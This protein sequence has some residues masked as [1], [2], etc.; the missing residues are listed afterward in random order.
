MT[1]GRMNGVR[2]KGVPSGDFAVNL[3]KFQ[4]M[5]SAHRLTSVIGFSEPETSAMCRQLIFCV[6]AVVNDS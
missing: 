2:R 1:T 4:Q 6:T 5:N 3:F